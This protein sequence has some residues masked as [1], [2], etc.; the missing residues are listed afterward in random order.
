[1]DELKRQGFTGYVTCEY[2]HMSPTLEK[3]VGECV[4]WFRKYQTGKL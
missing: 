4:A 1:M 2:E 3:E